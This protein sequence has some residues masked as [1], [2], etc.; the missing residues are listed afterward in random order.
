MARLAR[1]RNQFETKL[2]E[3]QADFIRR[4]YFA[5]RLQNPEAMR[6]RKG[7]RRRL[8]ETFKVSTRTINSVIA[9]ER[10][11]HLRRKQM[12]RELLKAGNAG[13]RMRERTHCPLGHPYDDDNTI[14]LLF[15]R[16]DGSRGAKRQCRKCKVAWKQAKRNRLRQERIN[17]AT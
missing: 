15:V 16:A 11:A 13:R 4:V 6:I 2:T 3:T 5:Y 7:L 1:A 8:A 14:T 10:W 17:A 12:P 9:G